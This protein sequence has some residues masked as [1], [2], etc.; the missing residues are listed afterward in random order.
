MYA[1]LLQSFDKLHS[2]DLDDHLAAVHDPEA[3][4]FQWILRT[5]IVVNLWTSLLSGIVHFTG[6]PGCGKTVLA[7]M[8]Y[9]D[10]VQRIARGDAFVRKGNTTE[11]DSN[12]I[13]LL[14]FACKDT[15]AKR[16]TASNLLS[17]L[18][19]QILDYLGQERNQHGILFALKEMH[20]KREKRADDASDV[21]TWP[22]LQQIFIKLMTCGSFQNLVCVV[23]ALDECET[24]SERN[25]LLR[26]F[27]AA[28]STGNQNGSCFRFLIT[29][30]SYHD[31][32]FDSS[33]ASCIDLDEEGNMDI[34]LNTFIQ[35]GVSDLLRK[36]PGYTFHR[37]HVIETLHAR[38]DKMYLLVGLLLQILEEN[39][40]SS[41]NAVR[42]A[43][44]MLPSDLAG[45]YHRI[46]S[47]IKARDKNRAEVW[48]S[49]ILLAF[50]SLSVEQFASAMVVRNAR[51]NE[52][53]LELFLCLKQTLQE[54]LQMLFGP[55][56]HFVMMDSDG[57]V[58]IEVSH[59]TVKDY[60]LKS[61]D[62]EISSVSAQIATH[63]EMAEA[64]ISWDPAMVCRFDHMFDAIQKHFG[65]SK[66]EWTNTDIE[67]AAVLVAEEIC[68]TVE[69]GMSELPRV[70]RGSSFSSYA[71]QNIRGHI[72]AAAVAI[73]TDVVPALKG[74]SATVENEFLRVIFRTRHGV[75]IR[76][77]NKKGHHTDLLAICD[78]LCE[79]NAIKSCVIDQLGLRFKIRGEAKRTEESVAIEGFKSAQEVRS[80]QLEFTIPPKP[81]VFKET[82]VVVETL[83]HDVLLGLEHFKI[84]DAAPY[85]FERQ[86]SKIP[87]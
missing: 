51:T 72:V 50:Q 26:C 80:V 1:N 38:A 24:G 37:S 47:K 19:A 74:C 55:L 21:W 46:W 27:E 20:G 61:A 42:E 18:I 9:K 5:S 30:R 23:D 83:P 56:I 34:D 7:K 4:T 76:A 79:T 67:T 64:C 32:H 62:S 22:L 59:Q 66:P 17:G 75:S 78:I 35:A 25:S 40:D 2:M 54:D 86:W 15:D 11:M 73:V 43:L 52:H 71:I 69:S 14:F 16:R 44:S 84:Q 53:D 48:L 41:P 6:K 65:E 36:R 33:H 12:P 57:E 58:H 13:P 29:S 70:L 49:W 3:S 45:V 60:F 39:T 68:P 85:G 82:F 63:T 31:L 77:K 10:S 8:L 87:L 28:V 81:E